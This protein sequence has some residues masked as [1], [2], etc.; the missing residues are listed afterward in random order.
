[1]RF[2]GR[3]ALKQNTISN[4]HLETGVARRSCVSLCGVW[5]RFEILVSLFLLPFFFCNAL[6]KVGDM[7][8][9]AKLEFDKVCIVP[10][11]PQIIVRI[12]TGFHSLLFVSNFSPVF[13]ENLFI[14]QTISEKW[15]SL[16]FSDIIYGWLEKKASS[17]RMNSDSQTK[18]I[19]KAPPHDRCFAAITH[20]SELHKFQRSFV[21]M[22]RGL[23]AFGKF[24]WGSAL[25][26]SGSLTAH[27]DH[28][29][30]CHPALTPCPQSV[31]KQSPQKMG[32]FSGMLISPVISHTTSAQSAS[33]HV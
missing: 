8:H 7:D 32:C 29:S 17:T 12:V 21:Q 14:H 5:K 3:L 2:Q 30:R 18:I 24:V 33:W 20:F 11:S 28:P 13:R 19:M 25:D 6:A 1:M 4:N 27:P 31:S 15:A 16:I 10:S 26:P 9:I 22:E 23:R